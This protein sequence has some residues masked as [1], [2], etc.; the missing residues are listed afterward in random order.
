MS[1]DDLR[2]ADEAFLASSVRSVLRVGR[3][4]GLGLG[5]GKPSAAPRRLMMPSRQL[6]EAQT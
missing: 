1:P 6:V 4:D 5:D 2:R 3:V